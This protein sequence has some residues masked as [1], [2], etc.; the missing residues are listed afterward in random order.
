MSV[1]ALSSADASAAA[2]GGGAP[3][4]AGNEQRFLKLLVTQLNNQDPL[5]PMENA[6]LTSQ[7]AQMSTVSG[8]EKMN[9]TLQALVGQGSAG[10]LLQ[11]A[12]MV[13]RAVL[14]TGNEIAGGDGPAA[15]GVELP[16]SAASVQAVITDA[17]GHP[18]RTLDLGALPA[19]RHA[20]AW[21][22]KDDD[23]RAVPAGV[24]RVQVDAANGGQPVPATTL[25]YDQVVSVTQDGAGCTLDLSTGRSISLADVRMLR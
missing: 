23:G 18:V 24:Y 20:Q 15:F 10:Q 2:L 6:Q 3:A 5:N 22:G 4:S 8:I 9:A 1:T 17:A 16:A 19:G 21:D 12:G 25:V 11:A 13:G 7:L 14:A